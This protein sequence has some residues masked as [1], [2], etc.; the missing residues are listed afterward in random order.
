MESTFSAEV[1]H[2]YYV[3]RNQFYPHDIDVVY[4]FYA[5]GIW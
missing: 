1:L 4:I 5:G 3:I 2:F